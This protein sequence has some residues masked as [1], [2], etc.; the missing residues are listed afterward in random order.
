MIVN[1]NEQNG[2]NVGKHDLEVERTASAIS[3]D[4]THS[5]HTTFNYMN[6]SWEL[7]SAWPE[8]AR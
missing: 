6:S 8:M 5:I 1:E 2:N 4:I 7:G 3:E